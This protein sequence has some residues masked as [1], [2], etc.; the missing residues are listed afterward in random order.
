MR[1]IDNPHPHL[2][3]IALFARQHINNN[4]VT[5]MRTKYNK[6]LK[7][8]KGKSPTSTHIQSV[9]WL[10]KELQTAWFLAELWIICGVVI[11][12]F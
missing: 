4:F 10:H 1:Y 6:M 9:C 3:S 7:I 12:I 8:I 11:Q 2:P 5:D